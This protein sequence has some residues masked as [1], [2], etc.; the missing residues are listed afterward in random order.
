M[1][2]NVA[3]VKA[4][5]WEQMQAVFAATYADEIYAALRD[6]GEALV[7]DKLAALSDGERRVLRNVLDAA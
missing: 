5:S 2:T 4:M 3:A 7:R 6:G 1:P